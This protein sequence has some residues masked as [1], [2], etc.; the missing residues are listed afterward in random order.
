MKESYALPISA[1]F[2][3][4]DSDLCWVYATLN[5]LETNYLHKHP[6]SRIELSRA[7][8]QLSSIDDSLSAH[9]RGELHAFGRWRH[10]RGRA[11]ADP[12]PMA[13]SR[14]RIFTTSSI[15]IRSSRSI[16]KQLARLRAEKDK[17]RA[18]D[19]ALKTDLGATPAA[20]HLDGKTLAPH[21]LAAAVLGDDVW[22]E[23]DVTKD[24]A[25]RIGPS[26]DPDARARD[27][28]A[29]RQA[30]HRPSTSSTN[31]SLAARP[32]SGARQ[33]TTRCS[34]TAANTTPQASRYH[35]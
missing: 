9:D 32:L 4:G 16:P 30:L 14:A 18:L 29:L 3:Q 19:V 8:L 23:F 22:G 11:G 7:A 34:S 6:G 27:Q 15:P 17:E 2:D 12:P 20:T 24:G 33:T 10:R 35:I 1:P 25:E 21:A 31:R 26:D 28:R 13:S 5:M